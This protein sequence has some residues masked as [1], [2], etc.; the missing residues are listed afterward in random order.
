MSNDNNVNIEQTNSAGRAWLASL[1][2][3]RSGGF[4]SRLAL[5]LSRLGA[6]PRGWRRRLRR[7]AAVTMAAAALILSMAGSAWLAPPVHAATITVNTPKAVIAKDG[8]CSLTEAII[9]A[10]RDDRLYNSKGECAQGSG[11][12]TIT[13]KSN[14][15]LT[16]L[17]LYGAFGYY[18]LPPVY[19]EI[20]IEGNG[21]TISAPSVLKNPDVEEVFGIFYNYFD[22]DLELRN[23][24]LTGGFNPLGGSIINLG[25]LTLSGVTISDAVALAGGGIM[26]IDGETTIENSVISGNVSL[27]FG[28]GI[29]AFGVLA[30]EPDEQPKVTVS[31]G[32]LITNNY[33]LGVGGGI[34]AAYAQVTVDGSTVSL[35]DAYPPDF[36]P[37][38]NGMGSPRSEIVTS[39]RMAAL[40]DQLE[41]RLSAASGRLGERLSA[42]PGWAEGGL[43][44][45]M[46]TGERDVSADDGI[47]IPFYNLYG[48]GGGIYSGDYGTLTI[49][50]STITGNKAHSNVGGGGGVVI[51]FETTAVIDNTDITNNESTAGFG[52]GLVNL[53]YLEMTRSTVDGNVAENAGGMALLFGKSDILESTISFNEAVG[54]IDNDDGDGG[55]IAAVCGNTTILNSTISNNS[56]RGDGGGVF[57]AVDYLGL[58]YNADDDEEYDAGVRLANSTIV[59]NTAA[60]G[61]GIFRSVG[62]NTNHRTRTIFMSSLIVSGN[63]ALNGNGGDNVNTINDDSYIVTLNL[64]GADGDGGYAGINPPPSTNMILVPDPG[65]EVSDILDTTLANNGGPTKTHLL[66]AGSP[67]I[68][69][70]NNGVCE[71][72]TGDITTDQR[73]EPRNVDGDNTPSA[74]ECDLGAVEGTERIGPPA[75]YVSAKAAGT[76]GDGQ[77]FDNSDILKWDGQAWSVWFDGS[78]QLLSPKKSKHNTSA[79]WTDG[80]EAVMAFAQNGRKIEGITPIVE[81]M[82]LVRWDPLNGFSL[83]FDG[84]DVG[85]EKKG[86]EKIDGLHV[87]PGSMSPIGGSCAHYLLISTY[88]KGAVPDYPSGQIKFGGEDVLGFCM[89]NKGDA[90]AGFWHIAFDGSAEGLPMN[91]ID[92]ISA[93]ADGRTLYF[94]TNKKTALGDRD[95]VFSF[96]LDSHQ[97]D[98]PFFSAAES[99]LQQQMDALQMGED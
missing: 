22:G 11:A 30:N 35:N 17:F 37:D 47:P 79:I 41:E 57:I 63:T 77:S 56:A 20:I 25:D 45:A 97:F 33:S 36:E 32:T 5:G 6:L 64:F 38:G 9:N 12:D 68:D 90:T 16:E 23:V 40:S 89:T 91:A 44:M 65:V 73:G 52:G 69:K 53:G 55:G 66:V 48:R 19:S 75:V 70:I 49:N 78:E 60:E 24:T 88:G 94:T 67:A 29:S 80:N 28:G 98:G 4:I 96:N 8:K 3:S 15:K 13:L 76:T 34:G 59:G 86:P 1:I 21:R 92:S 18:G 39:G 61:G 74:E 93:G 42:V 46:L 95:T 10:N 81:G 27:L 99:G 85:L 31:D 43:G 54:E 14:V 7:R 58:C 87:L 62:D 72:P 84:S 2:L 26:S 50:D 51:G 82:D 83:W 71:A